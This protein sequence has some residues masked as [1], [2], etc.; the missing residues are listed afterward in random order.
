MKWIKD[1]KNGKESVSLTLLLIGFSVATAALFLLDR[2]TAS[3]WALVVGTVAGLY[4]SRRS[5][6]IN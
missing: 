6:K 3:D 4:W 5:S 2:F 1:P